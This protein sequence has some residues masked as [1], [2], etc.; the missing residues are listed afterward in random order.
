[1]LRVDRAGVDT[2]AAGDR[3]DQPCHDRLRRRRLKEAV[4]VLQRRRLAP[5]FEDR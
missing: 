5:L 1:L 4:L 2:E 3:R